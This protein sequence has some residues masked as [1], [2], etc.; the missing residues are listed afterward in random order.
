MMALLPETVLVIILRLE[1]LGL[2]SSWIYMLVIHVYRVFF[3]PQQGYRE[4]YCSPQQSLQ[5]SLH[6]ATSG[7]PQ[8]HS[9]D[10]IS[11]ISQ[12]PL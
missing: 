5:Q 10:K 7:I 2:R 8:S 6:C 4:K 12:V 1:T 3:T 11:G 9:V